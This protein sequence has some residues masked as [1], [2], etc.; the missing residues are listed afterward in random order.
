M[1]TKQEQTFKY[2]YLDPSIK[3]Y[4]QR[5]KIVSD[6]IEKIPEE[7]LT[8][9]YLQEL[10]KYLL[11]TP[12]NK[13]TKE[14][15]TENRLITINKRESSFEG[16]VEKFENGQDGIYNYM[17]GGDKNILL[18]LKNKITEKDLQ[19]IPGLRQ[20]VAQIKKIEESQKN[21]LGKKKYLLT[22]QLIQMR[23]TQYELKESY[24]PTV[25]L[26]KSMKPNSK[27][28]I[29]Q[30]NYL[31]SN[32][33]PQSDSGISFFNANHVS[34]LLINYSYLK[35]QCWGEFDTDLYFLMEDFDTIVDKALKKK[36]PM[37]YDIV[38]YKIDGLSNKEISNELN[39]KY[40]FTYSIEY[41][42]ALWRKKIP[43]IIA[44]EAKKEWLI[45]HFTFEEKGQWKTCSSCKEVKLAHSYFF[46]KNNTTK[47]GFYSQC[48][49]C[50]NKKR[51][52]VTVKKKVRKND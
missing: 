17:T 27:I 25:K 28:Q 22:K 16:I 2:P 10:A 4:Q 5:N 29:I 26:G 45:W 34:Q 49:E 15:L 46:T 1:E 40:G 24:N 33:Q 6:I 21:A 44:E 9:Y 51:K 31:N 32:K 7:K 41:L 47:D 48:K 19:T 23:K 35:Q 39:K 52:K 12:Q 42:S 20:L 8:G 11:I 43:K 14:I 18:T 30:Q 13:K 36:H 37:F 3:D 50:R 38:I